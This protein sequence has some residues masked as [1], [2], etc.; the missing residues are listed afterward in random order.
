[1]GSGAGGL[2]GGGFEA[3]EFRVRARDEG[4]G[5]ERGEDHVAV[6]EDVVD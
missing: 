6:C 1:V 2:E 4:G 5:E 3:R